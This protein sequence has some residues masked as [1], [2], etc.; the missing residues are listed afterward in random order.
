M[1]YTNLSKQFTAYIVDMTAK[2]EWTIQDDTDKIIV[3]SKIY[4]IMHIMGA[5]R[6]QNYERFPNF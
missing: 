2:I 3:Y 5:I 4:F 6:E 1:Q